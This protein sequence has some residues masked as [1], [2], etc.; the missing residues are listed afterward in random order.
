MR[1]G[2]VDGARWF[3]RLRVWSLAG[4]LLTWELNK[5]ITIIGALTKDIICWLFLY[6]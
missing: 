4:I 5:L 6:L 3:L 2:L 1:L